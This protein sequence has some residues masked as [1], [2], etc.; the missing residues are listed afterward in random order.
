[1]TSAVP[2]SEFLGMSDQ[3][4][5]SVIGALVGALAAGIISALIAWRVL[6]AERATREREQ[7]EEAGRAA[8]RLRTTAVSELITLVRER[9]Y[10]GGFS[11]VPLNIQNAAQAMLLDQTDDSYVV[12]KWVM[13]KLRHVA[14]SS[15]QGLGNLGPQIAEAIIAMLIAWIRSEPGALA[16]MRAEVERSPQSQP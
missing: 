10:S 6:A 4:W 8:I 3:F 13:L 2:T 7:V 15:A 9:G 5:S 14:D 12:Y 1:M 16:N 11:A